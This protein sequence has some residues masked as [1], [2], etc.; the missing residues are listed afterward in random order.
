MARIGSRTWT[1][2]QVE[3]LAVLIDEGS[4]AASAAVAMK[5]SIIVVRA[6]ARSLG[7]SFQVTA[8]H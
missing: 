6:K 8:S 5:R 2:A 7:K 3:Q 4:T 1:A